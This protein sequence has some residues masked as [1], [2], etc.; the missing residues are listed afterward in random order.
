MKNKTSTD[1]NEILNSI[2]KEIQLCR[3]KSKCLKSNLKQSKKTPRKDWI[4]SAIVKS[5]NA[6]KQYIID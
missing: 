2:I 6:K 5:C 4:T 1:P 3:E